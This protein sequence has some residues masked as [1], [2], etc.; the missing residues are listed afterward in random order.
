MCK[1]TRSI[2]IDDR[3]SREDDVSRGAKQRTAEEGH[4]REKVAA[5]RSRAI[6]TWKEHSTWQGQP[7]GQVSVTRRFCNVLAL[8]AA[9]D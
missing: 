3:G 7:R 5:R 8:P 2:S 6:R 9:I 4:G 1:K